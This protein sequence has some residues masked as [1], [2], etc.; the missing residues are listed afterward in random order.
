MSD[1]ITNKILASPITGVYVPVINIVIK[2]WVIIWPCQNKS[3]TF[4]GCGRAG[5]TVVR[6]NRLSSLILNK[7]PDKRKPPTECDR[8]GDYYKWA[9]GPRIVIVLTHGQQVQGLV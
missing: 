8:R 4:A 3:C 9:Q 6:T 2:S 5:L 7:T 1:G